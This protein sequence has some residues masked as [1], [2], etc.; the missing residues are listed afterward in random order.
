MQATGIPPRNLL[1]CRT[2]LKWTVPVPQD[3]TT[4]WLYWH[5]LKTHFYHQTLAQ[6]YK[7]LQ[8]CLRQVPLLTRQHNSWQQVRAECAAERGQQQCFKQ[9]EGLPIQVD[10]GK[11][12]TQADSSR[13]QPHTT[14]ICAWQGGGT[15][16]EV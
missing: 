6:F 9:V 10:D 7:F 15:V 3:S 11:T 12:V 8:V 4:L 1:P 14:R 13:Q 16:K 2:P 5:Q